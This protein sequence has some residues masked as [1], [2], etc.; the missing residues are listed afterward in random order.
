VPYE[1]SVGALKELQDEGKIRFIGVSNVSVAQLDV[2]RSIVDVVS[3]Q[4]RYSAFERASQD[5]L[6]VCARDGLAVPPWYPLGVGDLGASGRTVEDVGRRHG[7]TPFQ[8]AIAWLLQSSPVTIP[9]P[10]TASP[11]HLEENVAAAALRLSDDDL[12][13]LDGL[14]RGRAAG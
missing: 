13:R 6:D 4:N 11:E 1:K 9:I 14:E 10:G 12:A 8:V 3:V 5:V 7:A 2:A